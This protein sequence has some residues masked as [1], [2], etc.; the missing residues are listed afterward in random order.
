MFLHISF[1]LS[2]YLCYVMGE[3]FFQR[4]YF[5]HMHRRFEVF[6]CA[7][8]SKNLNLFFLSSSS[9][10][11]SLSYTNF[12]IPLCLLTFFPPLSSDAFILLYSGLLYLHLLFLLQLI[13]VLH[14]PLLQHTRCILHT[15]RRSAKYY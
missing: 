13:S 6:F 9:F 11:Y 14:K 3:G 8:T 15:R 2:F 5:A 1:F 4:S 12:S 10:I 7:L